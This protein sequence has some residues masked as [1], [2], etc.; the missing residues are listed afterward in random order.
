MQEHNPTKLKKYDGLNDNLRGA[1]AEK[2]CYEDFKTYFKEANESV[3][4]IS[5]LDLQHRDGKKNTSSEK[6]VIILNYTHC[7]IMGIEVKSALT[8]KTRDNKKVQWRNAHDKFLMRY[9]F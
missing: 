7:Y 1:V 6:D 5:G 2:L 8:V 9:L 3:L 4:L